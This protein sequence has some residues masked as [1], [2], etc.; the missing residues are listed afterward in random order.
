MAAFAQGVNIL[1][2]K[3][4]DVW[5]ESDQRTQA[6]AVISGANLLGCL[7]CNILRGII[8]K[9]EWLRKKI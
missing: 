7:F 9:N 3:V 1:H 8:E 2:G 4:G 6:I 5:F